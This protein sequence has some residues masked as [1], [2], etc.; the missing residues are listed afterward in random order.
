MKAK[1]IG[2]IAIVAIVSGV[3]SIILSNVF[4]STDSDKSQKAEVVDEIS[5]D[6]VRPDTRYFN[7]QSVNPAQIIQV[8]Q[9]PNTDYFGSQ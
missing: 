4:I 3:F 9:D 7:E 6:F 8:D 1:D 5:A 2:I